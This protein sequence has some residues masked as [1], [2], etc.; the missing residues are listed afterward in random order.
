MHKH[1]G[2]A[3]QSAQSPSARP[4]ARPVVPVHMLTHRCPALHR[5]RPVRGPSPSQQLGLRRLSGLSTHDLD[6]GS[7]GQA[8]NSARGT[9]CR[10]RSAQ[11]AARPTRRNHRTPQPSRAS[12]GRR[13]GSARARPGRER[14]ETRVWARK[15]PPRRSRGFCGCDPGGGH[16]GGEGNVRRARPGPSAPLATRPQVRG[17]HPGRPP[18][19]RGA[20]TP[21]NLGV[22]AATGRPERAPRALL[23]RSTRNA[24]RPG[25]LLDP[26]P[27]AQPGRQHPRPARRPWPPG[28]P[29]APQ[30]A[31]TASPPHV[32]AG[33]A[34]TTLPGAASPPPPALCGRAGPVHSAAAGAAGGR[35]EREGGGEAAGR[36][37]RGGCGPRRRCIGGAHVGPSGA[38]RA[39]PRAVAAAARGARPGHGAAGAGGLRT[40]RTWA[41]RGGTREGARGARGPPEPPPGAPQQRY[42]VVRDLSWERL[43]S[44]S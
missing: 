24:A 25:P 43:F 30:A 19:P 12:A 32:S 21:E 1:L 41:V 26:P 2:S 16:S 17:A 10:Q 14:K 23:P 36:K 40:P 13:R 38:A 8:V 37:R 7:R 34:A 27:S 39:L 4:P 28:R 11:D 20:A 29:P 33:R 18:R 31:A 3:T 22:R 6:G 9:L 42:G 15:H 35:R 5:G 44:C